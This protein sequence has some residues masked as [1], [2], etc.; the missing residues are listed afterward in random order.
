MT[1]AL[2]PLVLSVAAA[3]AAVGLFVRETPERA[4]PGLGGERIAAVEPMVPDL[5]LVTDARDAGA[6]E[7]ARQAR[8]AF[9]AA[10]QPF[11]T[12]DVARLG[13]L[14]GVRVVAIAAERLDRIGPAA[15]GRLLAWVREGG[16]LV[17][18][19]RGWNPRLA[20]T[21]G[22]PA[23][24][25]RFASVSTPLTSRVP[26]LPGEASMRALGGA[27]APYAVEPDPTCTVILDGGAAGSSGVQ[28]P[29][30]WT[31]AR[32]A[33]RVVYW[34]STRL[35]LRA[36]RGH[37]LQSVAL[38][39]P[40]RVRPLAN[41]AALFLDDFPAPAPAGA[42]MPVVEEFGEEV[43]DFYARRWYPDIRRLVERYG[44]ETTS[45]VTFTYNDQTERPFRFGEWLAV[46]VT[47]RGTTV[48]YGPWIAQEDALV[49]ELA[50]HGYNHLPL[51]AET[52]GSREAMEEVLRASV[53]R[54]RVDQLGPLPRTYVPP[55]NRVDSLGLAAVRR[56]MPSIG[57]Y[58][59]STSGAFES[60]GG[61][62]YG[63]EP[64]APELYALPRS[65][66][67]YG[68]TD[69]QRLL[70]LSTLSTVGGW[71]HFIHPDEV[72]A[73]EDRDTNYRLRGLRSPGEVGWYGA[74][75][76]GIFHQLDAWL[77][78]FREHY[79]WV[80][81][82]TAEEAA[83]RMRAQD[84]LDLAWEVEA[85]P[86]RRA[87]RVRTSRAPHTFLATLRPGERL[88]RADGARV[89]HTWDGPLMTQVVL[90]AT[91]PSFVLH[92]DRP[93]A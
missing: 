5:L 11:R 63:P 78:F 32:G 1:R 54:W 56:A 59:S 75:G 42:K 36:M 40:D 52:W 23:R 48:P 31:C 68:M 16:G 79:P 25:P 43:V 9:G 6:V 62:E 13:P 55:M 2:V 90:R 37:L 83:A 19:N 57:V 24:Q 18:L 92:I 50:F 88:R 39:Q 69:E 17:V 76:D 66:A 71:G 8:R 84:A 85:E 14:D 28:P 33:G 29:R 80:E 72:L 27:D 82:V 22:L 30:V 58:A 73:N 87:M 86:E 74:S 20:S 61:R 21:L 45:T 91:R 4:L 15:A 49:S 10:H 3:A 53:R 46:T 89:L 35:A 70:M 64:W 26:L 47:A 60:G 65:T 41:W 34:N 81:G 38:A 12:T 7:I 51:E 44:L 93:E 77:A 67:G